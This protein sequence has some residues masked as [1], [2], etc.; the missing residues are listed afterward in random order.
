[1]R[2][3]VEP[4]G[5]RVGARRVTAERPG[6][7]LR[8]EDAAGVVLAETGADVAPGAPHRTRIA[9]DVPER[10]VLRVLHGDAELVTWD[11][12]VPDAPDVVPATE[13]PAPAGRGRPS[14]SSR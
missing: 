12:R 14:R 5:V 13:P 11:S 8:L 1:M 9:L 3:D 7:R 2:V 6:C 10:L 4:D